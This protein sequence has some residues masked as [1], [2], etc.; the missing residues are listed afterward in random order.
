MGLQ[1]YDSEERNPPHN[2]FSLTPLSATLT[3]LDKPQM[4]QG[5][6]YILESA[7]WHPP[8]KWKVLEIMLEVGVKL[9]ESRK[10]SPTSKSHNFST[11][12]LIDELFTFL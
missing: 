8:P 10:G 9:E 3:M 1:Q 4:V 2:T 11:I 5:Q 6:E 7:T 12:I